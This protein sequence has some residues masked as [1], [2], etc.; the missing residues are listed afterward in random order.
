MT[1]P[2]EPRPTT[3][4]AESIGKQ[5]YRELYARH[6]D[7]VLNRPE[8]APLNTWY[9]ERL[10]AIPDIKITVEPDLF[11]EN[12]R[13][14]YGDPSNPEV[15]SRIDNGNFFHLQRV[16]I[17]KSKDGKVI[18]A[19]DQLETEFKSIDVEINKNGQ[20]M[21]VATTGFVIGV[22]DEDGSMLVALGHEV[23][24]R[25]PQYAA[26]KSAV[27]MSVGKYQEILG[28]NKQADPVL[29][30]VIPHVTGGS[31]ADFPSFV[32]SEAFQ[33]IPLMSGDG[34]RQNTSMLG[35]V[36]TIMK[37]DPKHDALTLGGEN[38]WIT[39]YEAQALASAQLLNNHTSTMVELYRGRK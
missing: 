19:W 27:Q 10:A 9:R 5:N 1:T 18:Q 31:V 11:S 2:E 16:S 4:E 3:V 34:N 20:K 14:V 23:T 26:V 39:P 38:R 21:T 25:S 15:L 7:S 30:A 17:T 13:P 12:V 37:S 6:I 8:N 33:A 36:T 32:G 29:V 22:F 28:G 35:H 24:T